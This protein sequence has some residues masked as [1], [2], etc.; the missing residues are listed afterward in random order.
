LNGNV[1][2][3]VCD[4]FVGN[5][6]LK[7]GESV[8]GFLKAKMRT[9]AEGS[10]LDKIKVLIAKGALR[11]ALSDLDYQ[12]HGGVPLL[13]VNGISII[14][15]GS[16]TPLAIENMIL[17][18]KEMFDKNVISKFEEAIKDYAVK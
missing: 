8:I 18:A 16:S 2:V 7:F 11:K 14:G 10:F 15:H 1:N 4:G 9:V 6:I 13:G 12:K 17:K 5:I 3:V